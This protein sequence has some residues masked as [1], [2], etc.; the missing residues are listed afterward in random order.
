MLNALVSFID[1]TLRAR[2]QIFEYSN[3]RHCIFRIEVAAAPSEVILSDGTRLAAGS[4]LVNLHLWNEHIRPF[5]AAG[6]TLGWARRMCR[7]LETS[8]EELAAFVASDPALDE[9]TAIGGKMMFGST[10]QTELVM[11]F[12]ERYGF[13]RAIDPITNRSVAEWLHMMGENILVSMIVIAQNPAAF[14][15]DL[16]RRER[17]PVYLRRAELMR[18]FRTPEQAASVRQP[19]G[20]RK[21]PSFGSAADN[22]K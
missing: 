8:L 4:C 15:A 12:A 19:N 14:R 10:E 5:P 16:F 21:A 9:I 6:P 22:G 2:Q 18:R 1:G 11:H 17:V 13:V 3:S 7:D 20:A